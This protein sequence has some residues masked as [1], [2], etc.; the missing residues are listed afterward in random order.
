[1]LSEGY[2]KVFVFAFLFAIAMRGSALVYRGGGNTAQKLTPLAVASVV[3][4][5]I[6]LGLYL[7]PTLGAVSVDRDSNTLLYMTNF[8]VGSFVY[9]VKYRDPGSFD[10]YVFVYDPMESSFDSYSVNYSRRDGARSS[11]RMFDKGEVFPDDPSKRMVSLPAAARAPTRRYI[12]PSSSRA[13][14]FV[15]SI[16]VQFFYV[17]GDKPEDN[18]QDALAKFNALATKGQ[19]MVKRGGAY[20]PL[21]MS[22]RPYR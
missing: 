22:T 14:N 1:M 8:E 7:G 18:H 10:D 19:F 20:V 5:I 9:R 13:K 17:R 15:S 16:I 21:T 11:G 4:V 6:L 3:C 2:F 12:Q